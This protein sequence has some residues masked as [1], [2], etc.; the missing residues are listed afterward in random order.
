MIDRMIQAG[1][2]VARLNFSHGAP[3]DHAR[4]VNQVRKASIRHQKPIAILADLQGPKI[5]TGELEGGKPVQLHFGQRFTI[6]SRHIKGTAAGVSTTFQALPAAV[7]KGDP[8]LLCDGRIALRV[9]STSGRD[10]ICRGWC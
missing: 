10:V 4:R 9:V 5:R 2:D 3:A 1:M 8:I 7:K 6:T